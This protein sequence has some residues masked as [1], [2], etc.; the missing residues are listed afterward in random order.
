MPPRKRAR[1]PRDFMTWLRQVKKTRLV[2]A[3]LVIGVVVGGLAQFRKDL[4]DLIGDWMKSTQERAQANLQT[5]DVAVDTNSLFRYSREG[6]AELV[7]LLLDAGVPAASTDA[8]RWTALHWAAASGHANVVRE[9]IR[10]GVPPFVADGDGQTPLGEAAKGCHLAVVDTLLISTQ[11]A[12]HRQAIDE[13]FFYAAAQGCA[14]VVARLLGAETPVDERT[15]GGWTALMIAADRGHADVVTLLVERGAR[16]DLQND[17][18]NTAS[19]LA[20]VAHH[21]ALAARLAPSKPVSSTECP[22]VP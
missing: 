12:A 19:A 7:G 9:L 11:A 13:A 21:D 4:T 20:R 8:A 6:N 1:K 2:S 5:R 10:R 18:C 22:D 17:R 15:T 14:P 3:L 16:L